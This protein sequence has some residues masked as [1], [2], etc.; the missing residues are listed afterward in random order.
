MH[1]VNY[2]SHLHNLQTWLC[3]GSPQKSKEKVCIPQQVG[4][5]L[6]AF[7][8]MKLTANRYTVLHQKSP[9]NCFSH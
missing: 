5:W 9:C 4:K 1:A 8:G 7:A 6:L 3:T 2:A